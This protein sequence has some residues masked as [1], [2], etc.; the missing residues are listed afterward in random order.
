M[1][2]KIGMKVKG[3]VTGLQP[4]G[5]FVA[6]DK[7]TQGLIHISELKHG[8]VKSIE[9]VVSVDDE[10][11]VIVLDVDEY[12][13]KISLSMRC[14]EK[15]KHIHRRSRKNYPRYGNKQS[16]IGF[17]SLANNMPKWIDE[18]LKQIKKTNE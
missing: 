9:E 11:D 6:L 8:Y 5:A 2:Y 18:G 16:S 15:P 12:T 10:V 17:Q 4:Y 7:E 1:D 14:L 13:K 3:K